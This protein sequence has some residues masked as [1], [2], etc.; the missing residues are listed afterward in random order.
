[1]PALDEGTIAFAAM[2]V[3]EREPP[4]QGHRLLNHPKLLLT[5]HIGAFT[6]S[7]WEKASQEAVMKVL[8][9]KSGKKIADTLP[10]EAPW[11]EH[12]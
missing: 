5:P 8:E 12:T 11:F 1:M 6:E 2:D 10:I 9:F 7:A 4:P 3:I